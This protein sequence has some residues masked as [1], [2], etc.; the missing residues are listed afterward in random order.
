[1]GEYHD[2][3]VDFEDADVVRVRPGATVVVDAGL[4]LGGFLTGTVTTSD[5]GALASACVTASSLTDV[6]FGFGFDISDADGT[7][8]LGG[9]ATGDYLVAFSDCSNRPDYAPEYYDDVL[10]LE[11]AT[12]VAVS[13]G[14]T[15]PDIDA[16]LVRGASVSGTVTDAQTGAG[17]DELCVEVIGS[18]EFAF[19]FAASFE[20]GGAYR[21]GGLVE[22]TYQ[23]R[24]ADCGSN[25]YVREFHEDAVRRT[26]LDLVTL[27]AGSTRRDLDAA[28]EPVSF[29]DVRPRHPFR[30]EIHWAAANAIATGYDDGSF[31]PDGSVTRQAMSAFLWRLVGEPPVQGDCT[32]FSDV[33]ADHPFCTEI[34]FMAEFGLSEG[35]ADGTF[36]PGATVDRAATSAFLARFSGNPPVEGDCTVFSDVPA[37]HPFCTEIAFMAE[38]GLADGYADGTFRPTVRVT[39]QAM[40]AFLQGIG[41]PFGF[42]GGIVTDQATS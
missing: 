12:L 20:E 33:P 34:A 14:V 11:D 16:E 19:G 24:F 1:V 29:A 10:Q 9:L 7:Y 13:A 21:V 4:R 3:A 35:Y 26:D 39:R 31:R 28:L 6:G 40:A 22:D 42:G 15:T 5:G 27:S 32:V 25:Q 37:D 23:V 38:F 8:R 2:D 30:S 18:G 41:G 17:L 36:R